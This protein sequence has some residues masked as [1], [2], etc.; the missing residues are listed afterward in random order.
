MGQAKIIAIFNQSGGVGKSSLTHNLGYHLALRK[1]KVLL[2]DM[3]PQASLTVFLGLE[4]SDLEET[5]Y[6]SL[7][8]SDPLPI[9][10]GLY[11]QT[12]DLVPA[13]INLSGAELELVVADMRE[14]RLVDA[15]ESVRENY[16][17]ILIDCPPSLG[18]LSYISLVAASHVLVP[19]QT[20]FKAL[21]GTELLLQTISRVKSRA[22]RRLQIAGFVP[23]MYDARTAQAAACVESIH[24]SLSKI[25]PVFPTVPRAVAFVD[26]SS[27]QLPLALYQRT[28]GAI[29]VLKEIAKLLDAK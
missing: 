17:C 18:I 8:A 5:I 25:A 16:D 20:E 19:I 21:K 15:L 13:N 6:Q 7:M 11:Q 14:L 1:R 2:V 12:L 28:H 27:Q 22:N 9:H 10:S 23:T 4:P 29:Q 24:Q 3:D 26:A